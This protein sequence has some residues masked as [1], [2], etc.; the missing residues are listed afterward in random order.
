MSFTLLTLP[1]VSLWDGIVPS[2]G[3]L[4]LEYV[5]SGDH[6]SNAKDPDAPGTLV[7][8]VGSQSSRLEPGSPVKLLISSRGQRSYSF[9]VGGPDKR[10]YTVRLVIPAPTE[11][12]VHVSQDIETLDQLLA[13][14]TDLSWNFESAQSLPPPLPPRRSPTPNPQ[15]AHDDHQTNIKDNVEQAKPVRDA[16]LRGRLVLMD[17][18]NGDIVGELPGTMVIQEDPALRS[19]ANGS[20]SVVLEMQPDMYD[21][22]TGAKDLGAIGDELREAREVI[23]RAVSPEEQD[24]IMKGATLIRC[25]SKQVSTRCTP[26]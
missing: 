23:V 1:Q 3:P 7:F 20:N 13:Q 19:G 10:E 5:P 17:E 22:C 8:H 21:A 16:D 12:I 11:D 25:V 14:Y 26:R 18:A 15:L 2:E 24:W 4:R 9:D 6:T